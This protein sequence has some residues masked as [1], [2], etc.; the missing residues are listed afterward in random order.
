MERTYRRRHLMRTTSV[1]TMLRVGLTGG[2]G[3][4]KST[5]GR[6]FTELGGTVVDADRI[7][8]EVVEP[9]SRALR[10]IV[11]R[12]GE[13][14]LGEDGALD[15]PALARIVFADPAALADLE[16][17]THPA[18]WELTATRMATARRNGIVVHDMP[19]LVEKGLASAYH[20][21]V[22]VD[23]PAEERLR[24]LVEDRGMDAADARARIAVQATDAQRRAAADALIPNTGT[25]DE[26]RQAVDALWRERI[27]VFDE[28]LRLGIASKRPDELVLSEPQ[29]RW[30]DDAARLMGRIAQALGPRALSIDHVGSTAIPGVIAKDV[31]DLQIGVRD[32]HEADSAAFIDA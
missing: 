22:V 2:I 27:L 10:A 3:S 31:I 29:D 9:G 11:E 21:V 5:V 28:N 25:I 32:L 8:R 24:R 30:P 17:I 20:L 19:I 1:G 4:G 14:M 26:L 18:I 12:F 7:A 16:G 15:R 23:A 13:D 6:R